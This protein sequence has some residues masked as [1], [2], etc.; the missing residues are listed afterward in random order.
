[1]DAMAIRY[2]ID[3]T[4]SKFFGFEDFGAD[5][6][7][8]NDIADKVLDFMVVAINDRWK[9]PVGYFFLRSINSRQRAELVERCLTL[10]KNC[11]VVVCNLTFDG[12]KSN[13]TMAKILG[14]NLDDISSLQTSLYNF[15]N[16]HIFPDPSH[17]I[18]LIR[19]IFGDKIFF[20]IARIK[21]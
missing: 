17:M 13:F 3:Y 10:L 21:E 11:G 4:G 12:C 9:I 1:M 18:K 19:N 15:P 8:N 16:T 20:W 14:C 5:H 6:K 7:S 2:K